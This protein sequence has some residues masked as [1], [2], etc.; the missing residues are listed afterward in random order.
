MMTLVLSPELEQA[1]TEQA[2]RQGTTLELIVVDSLHKLYLPP[3]SP[4]VKEG[5]TLAEY[6]AEY[7]GTVDSRETTDADWQRM[8]LQ[9]FAAAYGDEEPEYTLDLSK[10]S[11]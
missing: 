4:V 2:Q 5:E 11:P 10:V 6:W 1:I 7:I 8:S 3:N 9:Y